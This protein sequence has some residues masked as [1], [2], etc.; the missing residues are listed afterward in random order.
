MLGMALA[1]AEPRG[2]ALAGS[3][4][5]SMQALDSFFAI[6]ANA[7]SAHSS[8]L[9][10]VVVRTSL[11]LAFFICSG[12]HKGARCVVEGLAQGHMVRMHLRT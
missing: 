5:L 2:A 12:M 1:T 6:D 3:M 7:A 11:A 9:D 4:M 8:L 10:V